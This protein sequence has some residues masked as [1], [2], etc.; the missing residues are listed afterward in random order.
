MPW[1]SALSTFELPNASSPRAGGSLKRYKSSAFKSRVDFSL[2]P[3]AY[4]L[5]SDRPRR[6]RHNAVLTATC[7]KTGCAG[8][9]GAGRAVHQTSQAVRG[10]EII[11]SS[12]LPSKPLVGP[13]RAR[14]LLP[15][16]RL[17]ERQVGGQGAQRTPIIEM[18][19]SVHLVLVRIPPKR[20]KLDGSKSGLGCNC[21]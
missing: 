9:D 2:D 14:L 13:Q 20:K 10:Q 3:A 8:S 12:S 1:S 5:N 4:V 15:T 11:R 19:V 18:W 7:T 6:G 21:C 17:L 16:R